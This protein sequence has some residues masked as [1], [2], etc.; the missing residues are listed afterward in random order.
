MPKIL[1]IRFSSIGDIVLTT[2]VI[3]NIKNQIPGC[4][5]HYC[6]KLNFKAILESNPYVDKIFCYEKDLK[7]LIEK[8]KEEKYDF[9]IDLHNNLRSLIIKKSL[10]TK[11][12]S[13]D[14]LNFKKW[15]LVNFKINKMPPV[16]IVDRYME[17][18]KSLK[19]VNDNRGLDYFIPPKDEFILSSLPE[20]F[21]SN[22]VAFA[23][24]AA[25]FTKR[26]PPEKIIEFC[27]II[28]FPIILLGGKEDTETGNQIESA[29]RNSEKIINLCGKLS[30]NQSASVVKQSY[31][32]VTPDTGLMHIAAAFKKRIYSVWGNT[33][34]SLG[35][36]PYLTDFKVIENNNLS[37]RPCSK[38]GYPKCPKGHFKCMKDLNGKILDS[39]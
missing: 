34:P 7:G 8:L 15:L 20:A 31:A 39:M 2:P 36:Y 4:E 16:H 19:I 22:F 30:L 33:T 29:V 32:V 26:I 27:Q 25:H 23:I 17:T 14:K 10:N 38:I 11:A 24:G 6:T 3:R 13:F 5:L 1:I 9:V 21:R 18:T 28:P 12:F 37:C 35:M